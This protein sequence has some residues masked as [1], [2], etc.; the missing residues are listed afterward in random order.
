MTEAGT[1]R[2][3]SIHLL[4]GRGGAAPSSIRGGLEVFAADLASFRAALTRE[5]HTLKR[6]LTDPAHPE[7][8]RQRVLRRDPPPRAPVA[9]EAHRASSRTTESR[10]ALRRRAASTLADWI[11]AAPRRR[12]RGL[13]RRRH[14]VPP[15]HGRARPLRPALPRLRRA[16]AAHRP[17]RQR[18]QLL[19]RAARP[20]AGSS[21]TARC[22]ACSSATGRAPS[23]SSRSA[24]ARRD[25]RGACARGR[26]LCMLGR[27]AT[28][29]RWSSSC[30]TGSRPPR[31]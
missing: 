14:R 1:K 19:R 23:R 4:R 8:H 30:G 28:S 11:D 3:A 18:D 6:A 9:R 20:A 27:C 2:R 29:R 21:P 12:R 17:R 24:A 26:R 13:P 15:R 22:R 5:N 25:P 31:G 10:A 7:R 16:G